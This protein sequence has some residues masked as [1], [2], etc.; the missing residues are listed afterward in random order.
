MNFDLN[1]E[2]KQLTAAIGRFIEK[3]YD[4]DSRNRYLRQPQGHD[5]GAWRALAELGLMALPIDSEQGGFSG[6]AADMMA[7]QQALAPA[8]IVEPY[9]AS[10]IAAHALQRAGGH[11]AILS[12]VATGELKLAPAFNEARS[13]YQLNEV[14]T[15][16]NQGRL[17][18]EKCVITHG[19][20][21]DW[22]L[23]SARSY[24]E[25][26]DTD[27]ISLYLVDRDAPGL[28]IKDYRSID[29]LRAADIR[30]DNTPGTLVGTEGKGWDI[31]E[32]TADYAC[33]L[34]C[35]EAVGLID[36][37]IETT[38]GYTKLRKQF[39]V[40][41][42]SFQ[43]LQ[44]RMAD[45]LIHAEQARS[46]TMLAAGRY[47]SAPPEERRRYVSAAKAR[48][49]Q[50]ARAVGQE[51]VQLH[52]GI[53]VTNELPAA[54]MFKRLTVINTLFGDRDHHISRF[55]AQPGFRQAG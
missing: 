43:A 50:A 33:V 48:I 7:V 47:D 55:T 52:G 22:L 1:D 10:V 6:S 32:A 51:A 8:M 29:N 12:A 25:T 35:A 46:I 3:D 27:G 20:Q 36:A 23:V 40:P 24:G 2:Q 34:L 17:S 4:F 49:G 54:H 38:V 5:E 45:M 11:G 44:H 26:G 15:R 13:R 39:G 41:I 42:A 30:L 16:A 37:L 9:Q 53:G 18:G 31:L 14:R 19:A 21:A 28:Q